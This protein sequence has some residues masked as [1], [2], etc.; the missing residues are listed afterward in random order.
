M[1]D[2]VIRVENL[3][4]RYTIGHQ[5]QER[6]VALRDAIANTTRSL[7]QR[8][9]HPLQKCEDPDHKEFWTLKDE[10]FEIKQGDRPWGVGNN[11]KTAVWE[12]LKTHPEFAIDKSIQNKLLITV[13]PDGY[14]QRIK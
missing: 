4:K 14:L 3:S 7:K 8:I 6:Y 12:Y 11:P 9:F 2:F 1:S 5:R 13:A 10:S